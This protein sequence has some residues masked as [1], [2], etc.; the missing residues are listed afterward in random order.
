MNTER[1]IDVHRAETRCIPLPKHA[2]S[3]KQWQLVV[4]TDIENSRRII[5]LKSAVRFINHM[6]MPIEIYST[7]DSTTMNSCGVAKTNKDPLNVPLDLLYTPAGEFYF[8]P[9]SDL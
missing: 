8:Q 6:D 4:D 1:I 3:G 2:D 7:N 9:T 5:T